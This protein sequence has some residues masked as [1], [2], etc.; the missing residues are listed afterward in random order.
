MQN[1][2]YWHGTKVDASLKCIMIPYPGVGRQLGMNQRRKQS[3]SSICRLSRLIFEQILIVV[4]FCDV[5]S[6]PVD[7]S[8]LIPKAQLTES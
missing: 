1:L 2:D 6:Y 5:A 7:I 4:I 3:S 8:S